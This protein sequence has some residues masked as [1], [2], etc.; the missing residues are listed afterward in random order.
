MSESRSLD[1]MLEDDDY[2][3]I[4]GS[5]GTLKGIYVP[6][7]ID[8]DDYIPDPVVQLINTALGFDI[9]DPDNYPTIH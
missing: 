9:S 3:V 7:I 2:A 6:D 4:I 8:E 1:Y 5:D